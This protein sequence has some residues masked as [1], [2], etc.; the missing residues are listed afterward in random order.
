MLYFLVIFFLDSKTDFMAHFKLVDRNCY[1]M[2]S[3]A[4]A[5][6]DKQ[7]NG[8]IPVEVYTYAFQ[9]ISLPLSCIVDCKFLLYFYEEIESR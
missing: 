2:Y 9:L 5:K 1:E 8:Y 6:V 3:K 7:D 4:F